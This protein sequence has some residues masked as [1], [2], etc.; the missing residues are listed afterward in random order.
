MKIAVTYEDGNIFQHFGKSKELKIYEILDGKV[1][2]SDMLKVSNSGHSEL[3]ELLKKNKVDKLICGGIGSCAKS[4]LTQLGI[5]IFPGSNGNVDKQVEA[6]LCGELKFDVNT[7]CNNHSDIV[8]E[9]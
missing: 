2:S 8:E 3:A 7:E 4:A 6:Y 9:I 5:E 1:I